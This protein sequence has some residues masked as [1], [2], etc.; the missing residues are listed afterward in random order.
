M[1]GLESMALGGVSL[2]WVGGGENGV[3]WY[4]MEVGCV[5]WC[6]LFA[7][8]C[9]NVTN[10]ARCQ[11]AA[12]WL[13]SSLRLASPRLLPMAA[14]N[15]DELDIGEALVL[16]D[17]LA[18]QGAPP[19][20][21]SIEEHSGE[22]GQQGNDGDAG[23]GAV[24]PGESS[25]VAPEAPQPNEKYKRR[26]HLLLEHA[27]MCKKAKAEERAKTKAAREGESYKRSLDM[28]CT[29]I[30]S[31]SQLVGKSSASKAILSRR[32][33]LSPKDFLCCAGQ[34]T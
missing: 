20:I 10:C 12:I 3:G 26:G 29:L 15:F 33:Q 19:T 28:A 6:G 21:S 8:D 22:A 1:V 34:F 11:S 23:E 31:V 24:E 27:R 4:G 14:A 2:C 5:T 17:D 25:E 7:L 13:E 16:P 9:V 18:G 30:P 32:A